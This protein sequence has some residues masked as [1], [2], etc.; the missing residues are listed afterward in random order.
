MLDL[1]L[2]LINALS[3]PTQPPTSPQRSTPPNAPSIRTSRQQR[4]PRETGRDGEGL[5]SPKS[6]P[7]QPNGPIYPWTPKYTFHITAPLCGPARRLITRNLS[8]IGDYSHLPPG[9][10]EYG[11]NIIRWS[12]NTIMSNGTL[13]DI[14]HAQT[15]VV[16]DN[17]RG[18]IPVK[19]KLTITVRADDPAVPNWVEYLLARR[20]V[21]DHEGFTIHNP[22]IN[23]RNYQLARAHGHT[24]PIPWGEAA[25]DTATWAA[26]GCKQAQLWQQW[27]TTQQASR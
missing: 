16:P 14:S 17:W 10:K 11:V 12:E 15:T 21:Y 1:L 25:T 13:A 26:A 2:D 24:L 8:R 18:P 22:P 5:S 9:L 23:P 6:T 27:Q 4:P 19:Q 7:K 3:K 20:L